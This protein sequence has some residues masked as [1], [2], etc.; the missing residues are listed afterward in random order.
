LYRADDWNLATPLK[1]CSLLVEQHDN[2]LLLIFRHLQNPDDPSSMI[3]FA[4][5]NIDLSATEKKLT[6]EYFVENVVDSSRYFVVRIIDEKSGREARIGFGFRDRD[7]ATDFRE[8]LNYYVKSIKRQQEAAEAAL[9]F[10][11]QTADGGLAAK[12]SL[13]EGEKIHINIGNKGEFKKTTISKTPEGK[14]SHKDEGKKGTRM[15]L[16]KPPP[17]PA[18][19]KDVSISF[20]DIDI[21]A[22][23]DK[24]ASSTGAMGEAST[25]EDD[26]GN[27]EEDEDDI[28]GDFEDASEAKDN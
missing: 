28:F 13:N 11:D 19:N 3:V 6:M 4:Q 15:L 2:Q 27:V 12:L 23:T 14:D 16:K 20:G 8:S 1:T 21:N 9:Q 5:A 24:E 17:A 25:A 10:A 7:E 26:L 22:N 18:L